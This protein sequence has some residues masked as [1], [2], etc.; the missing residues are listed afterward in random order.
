LRRES[1]EGSSSNN[2]A[3][4]L[5]HCEH[6]NTTTL[7][8]KEKSEEEEIKLQEDQHIYDTVMFSAAADAVVLI[9]LPRLGAESTGFRK[10]C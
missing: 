4:C 1:G 3:D 2:D 8:R 7:E 10:T 6:N 9:A 5:C